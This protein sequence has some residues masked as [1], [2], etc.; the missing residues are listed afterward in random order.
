MKMN[1]LLLRGFQNS[2][3]LSVTIAAIAIIVIVISMERSVIAA[4]SVA[5]T[6][7]NISYNG[8]NF[9]IQV[10]TVDLKDPFLRVMPVVAAEGIGAV[11]S[12][13]SM[14]ERNGAV[15]AVNGTFFNAYEAD[16]YIRFPNGLMIK[17]GEV[18]HSGGN[19]ALSVLINKLPLVEYLK[20][21]VEILV[22]RNGNA[23]Y[24]I[25][26]WGINKYYGSDAVD[27][28]VLYTS[29]FGTSISYSGGTKV[30]IEEK[31][32]TQITTNAVM[33]PPNG[34]VIFIGNTENNKQNIISEL[35]VGGEVQIK[36]TLTRNS[37]TFDSA[38]W[39]AAIGVG[40]K[41]LTNGQVDV[42][43]A[44][45]GFDDPKITSSSN[46]RS[47]VGVNQNKELVMGTTVT[48]ATIPELANVLKAYGL[49]DAMNMDGGSSSALYAEG[50]VKRSP[51][52]LLSNALIVKRY[53]EP[54]VQVM[55]NSKFVNEFRGYIFKEKTM[56]PFRG[57][58]ERIQATFQWDGDARVL[59]AQRG[60]TTLVLRPDNLTAEVNG[61]AVTLDVAPTI[62]EGR[63]YIPLRFV[64]ETLGAQVTWDQ[65]LYRASLTIK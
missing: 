19:Q 64:A 31:K 65:S 15:A 29:D 8:K 48:S 6:T 16:P 44:R 47:F 59:K 37:G 54:Q 52:R 35:R 43:F 24:S 38:N 42:N 61:K 58:F 5:Y 34:Y 33:I 10:I 46:A 4:E 12:F 49:T 39:E 20:T 9:A 26:T 56:V 17:S 11:E 41:L 30:V 22:K 3:V 21:E 53:A 1:Q 25:N 2:F 28:V 32:I 62:R 36:S 40:P 45:D 23:P 27:Q 57:I 55:V 14:V 50:V 51:G 60:N 18:I 13:E 63:I 7:E